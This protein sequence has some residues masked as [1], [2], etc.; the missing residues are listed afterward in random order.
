MTI[1]AITCLFNPAADPRRLGNYHRF[2]HELLDTGL[3]L[4][5]LEAIFPGQ[6]FALAPGRRTV[7]L[8]CDADQVLW[9]KERL[10]NLLAERLPADVDAIAWIDA[11]VLF[12]CRGLV[13]LV[14][15]ALQRVPILQLWEYAVFLDAAGRPGHWPNRQQ[16]VPS[17]AAANYGRRKKILSPAQLHSGF[18]WAMRRETWR[19]MGGLY[20]YDLGGAADGIQAGA[21]IANDLPNPYLNHRSP[22]LQSHARRW[23]ATAAAAI[24]GHEVGYL[25][26]MVGHLY[27]GEI[28]GRRYGPRARILARH[29][30]DPARHI[31]AAP[32]EPLRWT[33]DAPPALVEWYRRFLRAV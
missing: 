10:L 8:V 13:D 9:Q 25:P 12:D 1:A 32:G 3:Q 14:E 21:W 24:A 7:Q 2:A 5:T 22:A 20:A 23:C 16:A 6:R 30:Y 28:A 18:A 15:Q 11:D 17:V 29:H 27:H 31:L 26:I 33:A 4:W 19:A